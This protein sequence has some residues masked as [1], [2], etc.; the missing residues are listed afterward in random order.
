[1]A[2]TIILFAEQMA[3]PTTTH[4]WRRVQELVSSATESVLASPLA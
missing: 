3:N 1:V 4:V 2:I